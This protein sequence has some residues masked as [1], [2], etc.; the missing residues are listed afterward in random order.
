[1]WPECSVEADIIVKMRASP[2]TSLRTFRPVQVAGLPLQMPVPTSAYRGAPKLAA[3]NRPGYIDI[4][5]RHG[6]GRA[7]HPAVWELK[8]PH[9]L[10]HAVPQAYI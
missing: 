5:A 10:A 3:S 9:E 4:L 8:L 2:K 1:M 7:G 6:R